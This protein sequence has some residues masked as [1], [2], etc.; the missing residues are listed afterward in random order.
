MSVRR[1]QRSPFSASPPSLR[2]RHD[3]TQLSL[4]HVERARSRA[5]SVD[6]LAR[7]RKILVAQ[8]SGDRC[9][10][11]A[12]I[13]DAVPQARDLDVA[14]A[15]PSPYNERHELKPLVANGSAPV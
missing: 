11:A 14:R 12:V 6:V 8:V 1:S 5:A 2:D 3:S 13:G 15:P 9:Y 10:A 4:Q 7:G